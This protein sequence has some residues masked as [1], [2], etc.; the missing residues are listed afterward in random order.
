MAREIAARLPSSPQVA[1]VLGS[2]LGEISLGA[3]SVEIPYADIPGFPGSAV[4][5]HPGRLALC[6]EVALLRGRPHYY[7]GRS[8]EEVV[9][10]VRAMALLGVR[11]VVLTNAA[12]AVNPAFQPGDLM[13]ITDHLNLMGANPL[14]GPNLDGL[15]LRF[16]DLTAAYDP[17]LVRA[18][19]RA[20]RGLSVRVRK[21]VYAA[22]PGPSYE[23]PAEVR[24]LRRLGADAVGM[25][26]VPEVIAARQ[27]GMKVLA[28]SCIANLAVGLRKEPLSHEEVTAVMRRAAGGLEALLLK[29]ICHKTDRQGSGRPERPR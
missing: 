24:M 25:S 13:I 29:V 4:A 18:T 9:R 15:G 7:E 28:I 23:T 22:F 26:T 12:G 16:P 21:G 17:G 5:G 14:R 3:A 8:M 20:A 10:P 11:T 27:A 1:V 19:E 2:G 6:G